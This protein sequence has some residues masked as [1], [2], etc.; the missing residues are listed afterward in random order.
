MKFNDISNVELLSLSPI[1]TQ[2]FIKAGPGTIS[3]YMF[4][5]LFTLFP[6]AIAVNQMSIIHFLHENSY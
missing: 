4:T 5:T 1:W 2:H 3:L 6:I